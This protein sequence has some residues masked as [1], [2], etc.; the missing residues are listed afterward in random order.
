MKARLDPKK[1]R[2]DLAKC[3]YFQS[4][5]FKNLGSEVF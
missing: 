1:L 5:G 3:F 4:G 2:D